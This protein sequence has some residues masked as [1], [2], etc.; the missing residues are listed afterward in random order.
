[1]NNTVNILGIDFLNTTIN[2]FI[3]T[4]QS[5]LEDRKKAFVVT[6]N[7]EVVMKARKE[8][9]F[10]SV[11][12]NAD[13]VTADGI[14]IIKSAGL[15]G[16]P[17]PERVTGFD[18]TLRLLSLANEKNYSVYLLGG[19]DKVIEKAA[20]AIEAEYPNVT[21]AGYHHGFFDLN[22]DKIPS[23]I[24]H[25][26]PDIVLV[27]LG[28]GRQ[29]AWISQHLSRFEHGIFMGVGGT[30]DVLA[31]EV[32]RAP[33][34]WQKMNLEWFYRLVKQPSRWKRQIALPQFAFKVLQLKMQQMTKVPVR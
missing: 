29:E 34:V 5:H 12:K 33:E 14:G 17:L 16:L 2:N 3:N 28:A 23:T 24:E 20:E 15:L 8:E 21:I 11:I 1:M 27:A 18:L 32:Q 25:I 31:G 10:M 7:P 22:D 13:Y 6:A 9:D 30:F 19:Q 4:L 26:K